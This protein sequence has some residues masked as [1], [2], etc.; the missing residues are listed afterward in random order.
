[1]A[2]ANRGN[3]KKSSRSGVKRKTNSSQSKVPGWL[4]LAA[5]IAI[6]IFVMMLSRLAPNVGVELPVADSTQKGSEKTENTGP[7]FDFYTLLPESEVMVPTPSQP[8]KQP[9]TKPVA[10]Q[11][12]AKPAAPQPSKVVVTPTQPEAVTPRPKPAPKPAVPASQPKSAQEKAENYLLQA[13]SFRNSQDADRLRA[14]LILSGFD[15]YIKTV[16][17]R[18]GEKWHRVQLGPYRTETSVNEVRGQ[19][20]NLGLETMLLRQR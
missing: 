4:W 19:L 18:G 12:P 14:Q 13:G 5:G 11:P 20:V 2:G 15:A 17:V 9:A 8:A 6:G 10:P 3:A 7:V 1:M 16:T